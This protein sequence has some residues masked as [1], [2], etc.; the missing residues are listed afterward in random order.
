MADLQTHVDTLAEHFNSERSFI[1]L[2]GGIMIASGVNMFKSDKPLLGGSDESAHDQNQQVAALLFSLGWLVIALSVVYRHSKSPFG[3]IEEPLSAK[4]LLAFGSAVS[5]VAGASMARAEYD[6]DP[7]ANSV[8]TLAQSLFL[9][10]WAGITLAMVTDSFAPFALWSNTKVALVL[11]G[12]VT[13]LAG[14]MTTR[15]YELEDAIQFVGG[16]YKN[17]VDRARDWPKWLFILGWAVMA[18]GIGYHN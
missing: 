11:I 9:G 8:S 15:A 3:M 10:G 14:V 13:T 18:L 17:A 12:V 7:M 1:A 5:V 6:A 2:L 4:T 16:D